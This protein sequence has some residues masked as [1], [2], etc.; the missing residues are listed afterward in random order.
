MLK[1]QTFI[2]NAGVHEEPFD[3][4][5]IGAGPGG[6]QAC[7]HLGRYN[8]RALLFHFPGWRTYHARHIENYLGLSA[9]TGPHLLETGL[10]QAE[11]F[12]IV[13]ER[14]KVERV[15]V[16]ERLFEVR[17]A[18]KTYSSRFVIAAS[19][20]RESLAPFKNLPHF[21]GTSYFTCMICDGYRTTGKK[22]LV[23]DRTINGA[24]LSVGMK[25]LFT[26]DVTFLAHGFSPRPEYAALLEE[27]GIGLVEG[28]PEELLGAETLE[29]VRLADGR[30]IPCEVIMGWGGITLND[31]YL[32]GLSLERDAEGFKIVTR[33]AGESSIT[34]LF[35]LG[36]LR[37]GHSQAIIS[38]GQGAEA[39][40]EIGTRIAGL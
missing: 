29:G 8:I 28:R 26:S 7:I 20:A 32:E 16:R 14:A 34:G 31:E 23:I 15:E 2:S 9:V 36:A 38:A 37:Q 3:C 6:L 21:F 35:V 11:S 5:V 13:I 27:E 1:K 40:I 22:L 10:A 33:G 18:G 17:A 24:R 39:A 4:I 12:G 19:G 25:Q 30:V